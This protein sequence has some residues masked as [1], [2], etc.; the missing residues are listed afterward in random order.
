MELTR[1]AVEGKH[2]DWRIWQSDE[3][4]YYA[5][6]RQPVRGLWPTAEGRTLAI[7]D[8]NLTGHE[9][10]DREKLGGRPRNKGKGISAAPTS[11]P[12]A[13]C[14]TAYRGTATARS[15]ATPAR[16]RTGS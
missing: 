3:G 1:E 2:P 7:L 4:H 8:L 10:T 12:N 5:S 13:P 11:P 15:R 6:R 14:S 16:S 9:A